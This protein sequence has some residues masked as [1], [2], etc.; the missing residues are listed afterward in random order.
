[1]DAWSR[2]EVNMDP[3]RGAE[4]IFLELRKARDEDRMA[5]LMF[6]DGEPMVAFPFN[7]FAA[8]FQAFNDPDFM[9]SLHQSFEDLR[10]GRLELV[11][12]DHPPSR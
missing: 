12:D 8:L 9:E 11:D 10:Q 1:M 5:T 6:P 2:T 3:K 4:V 7:D